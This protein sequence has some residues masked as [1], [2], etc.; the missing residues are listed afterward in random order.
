MFIWPDQSFCKRG[1]YLAPIRERRTVD[2]VRKEFVGMPFDKEV[3]RRISD[4][5]YAFGVSF[6]TGRVTAI[7][8]PVV[9]RKTEG[10]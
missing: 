3:E 7:Y 4:T 10:C 1:P 5:G 8:D 2:D 9:V 6:K